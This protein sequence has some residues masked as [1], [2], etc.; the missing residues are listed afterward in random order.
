MSR[1]YDDSI[2]RCWYCQTAWAALTHSF[3][4]F[5]GQLGQGL[6]QGGPLQLRSPQEGVQQRPLQGRVLQTGIVINVCNVRYHETAV[7]CPVMT[8]DPINHEWLHLGT[9]RPILARGDM[10]FAV[11]G[12]VVFP[13][14]ILH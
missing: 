7:D 9:I 13:R 8:I 12:S 14:L 6:L 2:Q 3:N 5:L 10:H 1:I 11:I 4:H